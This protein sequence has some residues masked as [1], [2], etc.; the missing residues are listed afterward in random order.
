ML[1]SAAVIYACCSQV[2][3]QQYSFEYHVSAAG[4]SPQEAPHSLTTSLFKLKSSQTKQTTW[5]HSSPWQQT[6]SSLH[7]V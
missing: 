1:I 5:R 7:G 6:S 2:C 3:L 4:S